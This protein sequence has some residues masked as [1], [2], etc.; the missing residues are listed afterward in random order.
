MAIFFIN[1]YCIDI[2]L[3]IDGEEIHSQ[4]GTTQGDPQEMGMYAIATNSLIHQLT[5]SSIKQFGRQMMLRL[6][7]N[8]RICKLGGILSHFWV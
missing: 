5:H 2:D 3:F 6:V 4:E 7:A 8:Y 1:T